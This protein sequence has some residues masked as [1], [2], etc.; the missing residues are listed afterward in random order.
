MEEDKIYK[1][2]L[3]NGIE[4]PELTVNGSYFIH[5]SPLPKDIFDG[6]LY[7][8]VVECDGIVDVHYNLELVNRIDTPEQTWFAFRALSES[9]LF[10]NRLRSDMDYLAMMSNVDFEE[11]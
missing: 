1:V 2:T 11:I 8:V 9:E 5:T 3:Y 10:L 7:K 4:I 6:N